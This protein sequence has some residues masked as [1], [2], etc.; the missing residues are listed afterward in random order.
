MVKP[1][2]THMG[3][4]PQRGNV[5]KYLKVRRNLPSLHQAIEARKTIPVSR[6]GIRYSYPFPEMDVGDYFDAPVHKKV[7]SVVFYWN[8]VLAPSVF[9]SRS[10]HNRLNNGK[11]SNTKHYRVVRV[12]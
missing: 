12:R 6:T 2:A 10:V 1:S 8:K 4:T 11:N 3:T 5:P 7:T 9:I